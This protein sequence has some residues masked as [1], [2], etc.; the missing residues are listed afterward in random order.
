[1]D[2]EIE[3][4]FEAMDARVRGLE[5]AGVD[6]WSGPPI[7]LDPPGPRPALK[8]PQLF[9]PDV[10][11]RFPARLTSEKSGNGGGYYSWK[12]L[13]DDAA[14]DYAPAQTGTDNAKE[15]QAIEGLKVGASDGTVVWLE[16][17]TTDD[18]AEWRF[19]YGGA[20]TEMTGIAETI[21][22][23]FAIW[24]NGTIV[25]SNS[26]WRARPIEYA[27]HYLDAEHEF[28]DAWPAAWDQILGDHP[29]IW[30][31]GAD[32]QD[33]AKYDIFDVG[34]VGAASACMYIDD[35]DGGKLKFECYGFIGPLHLNLVLV[36]KGFDRR[37]AADAVQVGEP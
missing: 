37:A 25:L 17:D 6:P 29:L 23:R 3:E 28:A 11:E 13:K 21:V 1:M 33:G 34:L 26:D 36:V 24:N 2:L 16:A 15:A 32:P 30:Y 22:I 20:V 12:R 5:S 19:V 8:G 10:P 9:P 35:A 27:V 31:I 7:S 18:P 14:T 4:R